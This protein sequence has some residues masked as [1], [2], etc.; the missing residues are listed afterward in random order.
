MERGE[1]EAYMTAYNNND[2]EGVFSWYDPEIVFENFG[3][4][5]RG[6]DVFKFLRE[7]HNVVSSTFTVRQLL[8]DGDKLAMEADCEIEAKVDLPHLP[9][10]PMR[11]GDKNVCRV[12]G[13]YTTKGSKIVHI[14]IA[15]WPPVAVEN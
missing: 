3:G 15:G 14:K 8:V 11:A 12:F 5:Q 13:F 7:L 4:Y 2:L 9:A 10:G 6:D 1:F